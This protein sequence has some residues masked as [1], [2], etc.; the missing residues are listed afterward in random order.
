MQQNWGVVSRE[1][2][3]LGGQPAMFVIV[4]CEEMNWISDP[5]ELTAIFY[6]V[7]YK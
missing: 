1:E 4:E 6:L 5:A 7:L 3:W 2:C